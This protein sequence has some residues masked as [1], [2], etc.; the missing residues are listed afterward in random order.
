MLDFLFMA[1]GFFAFFCVSLI[2]AGVVRIEK[3]LS[4]MSEDFAIIAQVLTHRKE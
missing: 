1:C 3:H 2:L 4:R